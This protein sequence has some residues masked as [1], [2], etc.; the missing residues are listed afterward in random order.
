MPYTSAALP[1]PS[2]ALSVILVAHFARSIRTFCCVLAVNHRRAQ[3]GQSSQGGALA[4]GHRTR[5]DCGL[6][7]RTAHRS[8]SPIWKEAFIAVTAT[9]LQGSAHAGGSCNPAR[10]A[11]TFSRLPHSLWRP[12]QP[13]F[14]L[15]IIAARRVDI[16]AHS[17]YRRTSRWRSAVSLSAFAC[18]ILSVTIAAR[19]SGAQL[20][21][22]DIA[23]LLLIIE[24]PCRPGRERSQTRL[25]D[26]EGSARGSGSSIVDP[27]SPIR[28]GSL[29]EVTRRSQRE[30]ADQERSTHGSDSPIR[31]EARR[32]GR[33]RSLK[34][35]ADPD[36]TRQSEG[37]AHRPRSGSPESEASVSKRLIEEEG[38]AHRADL[39]SR[40]G[41]LVEAARQPDRS[42]HG[43]GSPTER[44]AHRSDSPT[45]ER[46]QPGSGISSS[47]TSCRKLSGS[48]PHNRIGFV[49]RSRGADRQPTG[50]EE[51]YG[52]DA[53]SRHSTTVPLEGRVGTD[54][55]ETTLHGIA[56]GSCAHLRDSKSD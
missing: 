20:L 7:R 54:T 31:T 25:A 42:V 29:T 44:S 38:S 4:A 23:A 15:A 17:R 33:E 8:V 45:K 53:L 51:S 35:L 46:L 9:H 28:T 19:S 16:T 37:S 27:S 49:L 21:S 6:L 41:A 36:E 13:T 34:R 40:K 18:A 14:V 2:R 43:S 5:T 48:P 24:A 30:L 11:T 55:S 32:S 10:G 22:A 52:R 1:P 3:H 26:P 56:D 12:P 50:L 39:L 47:S